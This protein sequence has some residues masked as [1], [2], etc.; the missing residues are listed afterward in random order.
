MKNLWSK[1]A[2]VLRRYPIL[3]A[4]YAVAMLLTCS[5]SLFRRFVSNRILPWI[6]TR[7]VESV[8]G[9][10]FAP[11]DFD[12]VPMQTVRQLRSALEWGTRYVNICIVALALVL[13]A[14][15]VSVILR[16]E[17][18]AFAAAGTRL[19]TYPTRILVYSSKVWLLSLLLSVALWWPIHLSVTNLYKGYSVSDGLDLLGR[20]CFAWV[21]APIAIKL[22]RPAESAALPVLDK[23][24]ARYIYLA[25][26]TAEYLMEYL[27]RP[28]VSIPGLYS[29]NAKYAAYC[30][31]P[32][33]S[34]LPFVFLYVAFALIADPDLQERVVPVEFWLPEWLRSLMPLH[35]EARKEP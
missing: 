20:L 17:G 18:P 3:W 12:S 32:L 19:R 23:R 24:L 7:Q 6:A 2:F 11:R 26:I 10:N 5:L 8:L 29:S 27:L 28:L 4:P 9:G 15:M 14:M 16:G 33:I 30:F 22:L 21:M 25:T 13:T 34:G 31:S 1:T 35:S